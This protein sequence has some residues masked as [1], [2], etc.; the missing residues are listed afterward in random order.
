M[1][2]ARPAAAN[3]VKASDF[4]LLHGNGVDDPARIARMVEARAPLKATVPCRS[5]STK[6][7][8]STST[9]PNNNMMAALGEYVSWG[10]FDPEGYQCP[11]VTWSINTA[12]KSEFFAKLKEVTGAS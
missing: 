12:R 9:D 4:L 7:T 2:E 11:P 10:Y 1:A 8:T 6:T 3:V 5:C